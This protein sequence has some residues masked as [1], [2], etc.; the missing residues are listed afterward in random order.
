MSEVRLICPNRCS[1]TSVYSPCR[2]CG[3][4]MVV[5]DQTEKSGTPILSAEVREALK[6]VDEAFF[7]QVVLEIIK[8]AVVKLKERAAKKPDKEER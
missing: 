8:A 4:P 7:S 5:W 3:E 1:D 2:V 6:E